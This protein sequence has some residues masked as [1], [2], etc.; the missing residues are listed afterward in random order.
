MSKKIQTAENVPQEINTIRY[1][2]ASLEVRGHGEFRTQEARYLHL[3]NYFYSKLKNVLQSSFRWNI[4]TCDERS[5]YAVELAAI[6]CRFNFEFC[7]DFFAGETVVDLAK[8]H[9]KLPDGNK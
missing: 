5:D 7:I 1:L 8:N 9:N 4:L 3:Q 6:L 2:Y